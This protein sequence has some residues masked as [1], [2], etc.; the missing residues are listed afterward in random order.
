MIRQIECANQCKY[1]DWV[2]KQYNMQTNSISANI[3]GAGNNTY[4]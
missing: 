4:L 1:F 2:R 3:R